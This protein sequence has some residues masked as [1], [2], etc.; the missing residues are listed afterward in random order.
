MKRYIQSLFQD[1]RALPRPVY[2][3]IVGQFVNRFGA[4]VFPFLALF[5]KSRHYSMGEIAVALGAISCGNLLG[6]LAG[7]YLADAIGRRNTICLSLVTSGA[8][9]LTLYGVGTYELLLPFAFLYGFCNFLFGP[10]V[11][12]L[13]S[14]LVPE[15]RRLVA[16]AAQRLAINA[17]FA[18]GPAVAG[19]LFTRAPAMIFVGDAVTTFAFAFLAFAFLPHGLRTIRGNTASPLIVLKSWRETVVEIATRNQAYQ[20]FLICTL[21]MSVGF[22]Q[23]FS[24]FSLTASD[25]GLA[26]NQYGLIMALNGLIIVLIELPLTPW[27]KTLEPR[28]VLSVGYFLLALACWLFSFVETAVGFALA[29]AVFT[30]GEITSLPIGLAYSSGLASERLRGRYFGLRGMTWALGGLLGNS[31]VWVYG[32]LGNIWWLAVGLFPL[33]AALVMG[34]GFNRQKHAARRAVTSASA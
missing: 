3:I 24:T 23:M 17:G 2:V 15:E 10:P 19:A 14:D 6:P 33:A 28:R 27:I 31:G 29:V 20:Q 13:L 8:S 11:S 30:L 26:P 9:I 4:F 12:A 18:A 25:R 16:F 1:L 22:S 34:F 21:L 5:L 32:H 7:G